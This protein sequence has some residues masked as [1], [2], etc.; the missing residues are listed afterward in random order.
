VPTPIVCGDRI[1]VSTENNGTRLYG[2]GAGGRIDPQPLAVNE[3]LAPDTSTPVV[4]DGLVFGGSGVLHCLDLE[5]GLASLW[6][7]DHE[8]FSHYNMLLGGNGRVL[9]LGQAGHLSLLEASRAGLRFVWR[10]ELFGEDPD[11]DRD[12]WS[13]PAL[14]G[15]RLYVRNGL[16]ITCFVLD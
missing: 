3:E 8:A 5:G 6:Q 11:I 2:F 10:G 12:T 13:H 1:L 14:V 7:S 15:N 9:V 16:G 4:V